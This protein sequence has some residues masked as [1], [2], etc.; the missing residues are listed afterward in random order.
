MSG[1]AT[2]K[3]CRELK[4][5]KQIPFLLGTL[6]MLLA[7]VS[8]RGALYPEACSSG[9]PAGPIPDARAAGGGVGGG[10]GG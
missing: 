7:A 1:A 10:G 8:G 3:P 9:R 6:M 5:K 4:I 2:L